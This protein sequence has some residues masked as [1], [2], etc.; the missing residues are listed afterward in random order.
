VW[1]L[2]VLEGHHALVL[3]LSWVH[4]HPRRIAVLIAHLH[5]TLG[6]LGN[7]ILSRWLLLLLRHELKLV[8]WWMIA[9]PF[10]SPI[11]ILPGV[12]EERSAGGFCTHSLTVVEV[13]R[14]FL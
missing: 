1:L 10:P 11:G 3:Y 12:S 8:G 6:W 2:E 14:H 4:C 13:L 5:G 9:H 7:P